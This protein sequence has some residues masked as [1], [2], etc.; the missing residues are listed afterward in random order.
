MGKRSASVTNLFQRQRF[1]R[2]DFRLGDDVFELFVEVEQTLRGQVLIDACRSTVRHLEI[3]GVIYFR[4]HFSRGGQKS[5]YASSQPPPPSE[6]QR[7]LCIHILAAHYGF[8]QVQMRSALP[9]QHF[10]LGDELATR[11]LAVRRQRGQ[12]DRCVRALFGRA[13]AFVRR[14][15]RVDVAG[16]AR[17]D[18]DV[19]LGLVIEE[20]LLNDR[21]RGQRDFA[22]SVG[23]TRIAIVLMAVLLGFPSA[24]TTVEGRMAPCTT[25]LMKS[26]RM[27]ETLSIVASGA[28]R[29]WR[30]VGFFTASS[31][32]ARLERFTTLDGEKRRFQSRDSRRELVHQRENKTTNRA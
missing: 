17:V 26:L 32:P 15:V 21:D 4:A 13:G 5:H 7:G 6:R 1:Q 20:T 19:S 22:H 14:H 23:S 3:R 8:I 31:I 2:H 28:I 9:L 30:M 16:T 10:S 24:Q 12:V 29:F 27:S 11:R 18:D 25:Y